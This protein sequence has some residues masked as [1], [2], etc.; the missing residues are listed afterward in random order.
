MKSIAIDNVKYDIELPKNFSKKSYYENAT[1]GAGWGNQVP[2]LFMLEKI[3]IK[4]R[5]K[6][7]N[8]NSGNNP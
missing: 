8:S 2:P 7:D 4:K 6:Y 5:R 3:S 1:L